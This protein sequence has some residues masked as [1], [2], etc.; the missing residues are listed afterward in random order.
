MWDLGL[1][2]GCLK[3][4]QKG[5]LRKHLHQP[6]KARL[7]GGVK[8]RQHNRVKARMNAVSYG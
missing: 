1:P 2:Q 7:T 5:R 6:P 4:R 3:C 8:G